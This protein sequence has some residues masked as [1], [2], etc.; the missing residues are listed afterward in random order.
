M[1]N[2]VNS[3]APA[4]DWHTVLYRCPSTGHF[5][6][7]GG[8]SLFP[9]KK[10]ASVYAKAATKADGK[11]RLVARVVRRYKKAPAMIVRDD[12]ES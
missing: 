2:E 9:S 1:P 5:M 10:E 4:H 11:R 6:A 8:N 3:Y 12:Y 7:E